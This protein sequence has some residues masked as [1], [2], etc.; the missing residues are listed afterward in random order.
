MGERG[1]DVTVVSLYSGGREGFDFGLKTRI[2]YV[3][4]LPGPEGA[5]SMIMP[6]EWDNQ[7][8]A[9]GDAALMN[10]LARSE[11]DIVVT[12]TPALTVFALLAL[13]VNVRIVQEEHRPSMARG[14]TA[15]PLLRHSPRVDAVVS[16]TERDSDWLRSQWGDAAPK[17]AVIPN[18]LPATGRPISGGG[19]KV[20]MGAGRFVP[21]KGFNDLIRA[22]GKVT[23][24]FPEWRL[25]IFG[26][27]PQR[28]RLLRTARNLGIASQVEIMRPTEDIEQE[29][30]RASIGALASRYEGLPLV[31]LEA[32]AAHLPVVAYDCVTG[33][34][35]I[36]EDGVDGYL[37]GVGDVNSFADSL[38]LLMGDEGRCRNMA[39]SAER[40]LTPF[41]PDRVADQW[42]VLFT[43]VLSEGLS[44]RAT[45]EEHDAGE[46]SVAHGVDDAASAP[47]AEG[48]DE[49]ADEEGGYLAATPEQLLRR[50]ACERTRRLLEAS[51]AQSGIRSRPLRSGRGTSWAVPESYREQ[52]L[53]HLTQAATPE[54]EVRLYSRNKRLDAGPLS[55]RTGSGAVDYDAVLRVYVYFHYRGPHT[56]AHL[57]YQGGLEIEFWFEDEHRPGLLRGVRGN[58]EAELLRAEQ[59]DQP[60]FAPWRPMRS[61]PL[62]STTEFPID[63]VYTWVDG[64]DAEWLRK[65]SDASGLGAEPSLLAAGSAR[66]T[67][68]D[69]LRY[70]LRSLFAYAPWIRRVYIVTDGQRPHWLA[71]DERLRVVDHRELFPDRSVLPVFNSHAIET[72]LHRIPGLADH[73]LYLNDDGFFMKEQRAEQYF[74]PTGKPKFFVSPTKIN[75]LEDYAEPHEQAGM[76]NRSLI[77]RDYG[78]TISQGMLHSPHPHRRQLIANLDERYR[79]EIE[80][81]RAAKFRSAADL[82]V[83]SSLGQYVGYLDGEYERGSLKV[84]FVSLGGAETSGRLTRAKSSQIDFLAFGEEPHDIHP[85]L[86]SEM[87]R[88]FMASLFPVPSPWERS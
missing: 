25:R 3:T 43:D 70:S 20:V 29:W 80:A 35:E 33:P 86:T 64:S 8:C 71:E 24:E 65:K 31:L 6:T 58:D 54:L 27:G 39:E 87:A 77:E 57:G 84:S 14:T 26:D 51:F 68:R 22:F 28:D 38:R 12:S 56:A 83:M 82:S 61:L 7:F 37:V 23:E 17:L 46:M 76:N 1:H 18:A 41:A 72:V 73:F 74:A 47:A 60:L 34:R 88:N 63:A 16:L 30:A 32:R 67:N 21:S 62:W 75:D 19:Q 55:W 78:V 79:E 45:L 53:E 40:C 50:N 69:E 36:I 49:A 13:P 2:E 10:Y 11:A 48:H 52:V 42:E 5:P 4:D 9:T 81:T 44:R 59:F 85:E 15:A 66:Y